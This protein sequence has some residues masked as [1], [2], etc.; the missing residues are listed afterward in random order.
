MGLFINCK[1]FEKIIY[2][3]NIYKYLIYVFFM[4]GR[5]RWRVQGNKILAGDL[6][7][8]VVENDTY[9]RLLS[10]IGVVEGEGERVNLMLKVPV[11][12]RLGGD[13]LV[14]PGKWTAHPNGALERHG[15]M[16]EYFV[17][18]S[19]IVEKL[20]ELD[21]MGIPLPRFPMARGVINMGVD[22]FK[23]F[24]EAV[25]D[26]LAGCVYLSHFLENMQH[27]LY[28][29]K[30]EDSGFIRAA[31]GVS[32]RKSFVNVEFNNGPCYQ[33]DLD[34]SCGG[35]ALNDISTLVYGPFS[36]KPEERLP[37]EV[38]LFNYGVSGSGG[39]IREAQTAFNDGK[40]KVYLTLD[41]E[42]D[43]MVIRA[44]DNTSS[45]GH[46]NYVPNPLTRKIPPGLQAFD[47]VVEFVYEHRVTNEGRIK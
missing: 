8:L 23:K 9:C 19:R 24:E 3:N 40:V 36:F 37:G 16:P 10:P 27:T 4:F 30:I 31:R 42:E 26:G 34:F 33:F 17:K 15:A 39:V 12:N 32:I 7:S 43:Q 47:K 13:G 2:H 38:T 28:P 46:M 5:N 35:F 20:K 21:R 11:L 45:D 14:L 18:H 44:E 1:G 29:I 41:E 22:R 6:A 25:G